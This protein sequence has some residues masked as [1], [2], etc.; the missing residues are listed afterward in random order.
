MKHRAILI[1]LLIASGLYAHSYTCNADL[2]EGFY[3]APAYYPPPDTIPPDSIRAD[4]LKGKPR[5]SPDSL[6]APVHYMADE[7]TW[8]DVANKKVYLIGN[9]SVEYK[10]INLKADSIVFDWGTNEVIAVGRIDTSGKVAGKPVFS[11]GDRSYNAERIAYNFKT[12][13]GKITEITTAEG[14]GYIRS[15]TVKRLPNEVLYGK[16]NKYTTCSADHPHFYIES[17]KIKVIPKKAIVTGPANLVVAD[18]RTPL[19]A[20]F[21]IFPLSDSRKSGII[22]PTYGEREDLG[23][24]LENGGYY[25]GISDH[26]DLAL[27]GNI[28]SKGSWLLNASSRFISKYR[29][30]G[31]FSIRYANTRVFIPEQNDYNPSQQFNVRLNYVQDPKARPNSQLNASVAFGTSGFNQLFGNPLN[32]YVDNV[33]QSSIAY[34]KTLPNSPFNFTISASHQQSTLTHLVSL[35]LPVFNFSM[36]QVYPFKRKVQ[37]GPPRWYEKIG[38]TYTMDAKNQVSTY[39]TLLFTSNTLNTAL[40]GARHYI[41]LSVPFQLFR[42][43]TVTPSFSYNET[44]AL[45]RYNRTWDPELSAVVLDTLQKFTAGRD[46]TLSAG[47]STR[48]YGIVQFKRGKVRAFRHVLN[49]NVSWSYR[50]D[51]SDPKY[52]YYQ[53][54]QVDTSGRTQRFSIF[55]TGL[56]SGP[57]AGEFNGMTFSLNNNLEMKLASRKDT[58]SGTKKIKLLDALNLGGGY[59][60]AA[61]SFRLSNFGL[62]ARTSL[63]D[64]IG[65]NFASTFDPY[66]TDST[67]RRRNIYLWDAEHRL[68]RLTNA[69]LGID[70][71]FSSPGKQGNTALTQQ[72]QDYLIHSGNQYADFN[73]PWSFGAGYNL[74]IRKVNSSAGIDSTVFTQTLSLNL[75]FSLTPNWRVSGSTS[76]DFVN[77]E[78]PTAYVEIY[79]DL[80]CW[81]MSMQWIPFGIRQSY[82]F[83]IRVKAGVLQDLKLHKSSDWYSY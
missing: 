70:A 28:Y 74:F 73:V 12:R 31:N 19:L 76:Y 77:N 54:V 46:Y 9:A 75:S 35:Q 30:S 61:D 14:E 55:P 58:V 44:W 37:V 24:Y 57:P 11:Q 43:V 49:P 42:F 22:V 68:V 60:F 25:F 45:Q 52:N 20:P 1:A 63:F 83:A 2:S 64:K 34:H 66:F 72:Q 10:D 47:A 36:N 13:K 51:F 16:R 5:S 59:N 38:I 21:G 78:F 82:Q 33:Y 6:D 17:D 80:H 29:F 27:T 48:L 53:T 7:K 67:G 50:P 71:R 4:S 41:P 3:S 23:F 65:L 81:E 26:F 40:A 39:D 79:R 15:E 62:T 69:S 18:V 56:Y 32:T 8:M